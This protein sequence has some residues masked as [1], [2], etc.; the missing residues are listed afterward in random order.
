MSTT[1]DDRE[2]LLLRAL[3][4]YAAADTYKAVERAA[5]T[6]G[7]DAFTLTAVA[8]ACKVTCPL[9]TPYV[10]LR[11][12]PVGLLAL[13]RSVTQVAADADAVEVH[14]EAER[15]GM[16]VIAWTRLAAWLG[17]PVSSAVSGKL[18]LP[19]EKMPLYESERQVAVMG[20]WET[21]DRESRLAATRRLGLTPARAYNLTVRLR[22]SSATTQDCGA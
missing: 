12:E 14:A 8:R 4:A 9:Y 10:E 1:V 2:E 15:S 16:G 18:M 19:S 21:L 6:S 3:A 13:L 11:G 20:A 7:L 17:T 22:A 5:E